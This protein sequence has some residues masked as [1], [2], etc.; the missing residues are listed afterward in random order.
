[1]T[2]YFKT[3]TPKPAAGDDD[4]VFL[5]LTP[6]EKASVA[7]ITS[8]I[9]DNLPTMVMDYH[10]KVSRRSK[11]VIA[12]IR[13]LD[14]TKNDIWFWKSRIF[15]TAQKGY[16]KVNPTQNDFVNEFFHNLD[17]VR[18]CDPKKG[19][20][21]ALAQGSDKNANS[22][23]QYL[24]WSYFSIPYEQL[25]NEDQ[26]REFIEATFESAH[27]ALKEVVG[28]NIFKEV[29]KETMSA[30]FYNT[31]SAPKHG[32][33]FE[34]YVKKSKTN[35]LPCTNL[36]THVV[37]DDT[38]MLMEL[39]CYHELKKAKYAARLP[40]PQK[41][42]MEIEPETIVDS[43]DSSSDDSDSSDEESDKKPKAT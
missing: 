22:Y 15:G 10:Y 27:N 31:I 39:L 13:N 9:K 42:K 24:S 41:I 29:L 40:T 5:D 19:P 11:V 28:T 6:E 17:T 26:E 36:N 34:T 25:Q 2:A 43:S 20:N 38:K 1:M 16:F 23:K 3:T 21:D 4:V 7:E 37:L 8:V 32:P 14:A 33:S 12:V 35:V 30:D 18:Q